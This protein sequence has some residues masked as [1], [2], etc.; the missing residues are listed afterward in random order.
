MTQARAGGSNRGQLAENAVIAPFIGF[1]RFRKV[2]TVEFIGIV[3]MYGYR[4]RIDDFALQSFE[5]WA[6][7]FVTGPLR[8]IIIYIHNPHTI[9]NM[10][11]WFEFRRN[12]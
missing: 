5:F 11:R 4:C 7:I 6:L 2:R 3:M 1:G 8:Q 12:F 9:E 10:A